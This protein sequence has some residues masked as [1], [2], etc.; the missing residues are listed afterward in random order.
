MASRVA[1]VGVYV[2]I[3]DCPFACKAERVDTV[4]IAVNRVGGAVVTSVAS[5]SF[6]EVVPSLNLNR[7]SG[8]GVT[9][10]SLLFF[11]F[12]TEMFTFFCSSEKNEGLLVGIVLSPSKN[13]PLDT[14]RNS[15]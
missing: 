3:V 9:E 7:L 10:E 1:V 2:T 11:T 4:P 15:S 5:A 6:K 14:S 12:N 13:L 8:D